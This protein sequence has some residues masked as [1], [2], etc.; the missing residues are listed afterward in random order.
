MTTAGQK[1]INLFVNKLSKLSTTK[2]MISLCVSER[3]SLKEK[4]TIGTVRAYM[5]DY[6]KAIKDKFGNR[7]NLLKHLRISRRENNSIERKQNKKVVAQNKNLTKIENPEQ[8]IKIATDLL[9]ESSYI[10]RALGLMLLTGRRATEILKTGKLVKHKNRA[11][12]S[13]FTGQLK[14]K[15][16]EMK[17]YPIFTLIDSVIVNK[18]LRKLRKD[19]DFTQK[20]TTQVN[21]TASKEL[22]LLVKRYFGDVVSSD[23]KSHD[24]RKIYAAI[25]VHLYKKP[26]ESTN[27]FLGSILGHSPDDLNTAHTYNKY[28]L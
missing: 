15:G 6:R 3:E 12:E 4:Y 14:T 10:K 5:T 7:T 8:L 21:K 22:N 23:I 9:N 11:Y 2:E 19:K 24:L 27:V 26:F 17:P 25:C 13:V 28:Y 1:R 18:A 20:T 16:I